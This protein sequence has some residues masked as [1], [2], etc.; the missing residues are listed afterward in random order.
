M[1]EFAVKMRL[2][3]LLALIV[4]ALGGSLHA[5]ERRTGQLIRVLDTFGATHESVPHPVG[6]RASRVSRVAIELRRL[7]VGP[8][9]RIASMGIPI[10]GVVLEAE[11]F[12]GEN[13]RFMGVTATQSHGGLWTWTATIDKHEAGQAVITIDRDL[14]YG[15]IHTLENHYT[16]LTDR[17]GEYWV[18][19]D[20]P[21]LALS[22]TMIVPPEVKSIVSKHPDG[23]QSPTGGGSTTIDVLVLYT[24]ASSFNYPTFA[25]AAN[26][27][28]DAD[29][30]FSGSGVTGNVNIVGYQLS[31]YTEASPM[32]EAAI[33]AV[34]VEMY[35]GTGDFTG[36]SSL[37][38]SL[39]AD[40]AVLLFDSSSSSET[41]AAATPL[42]TSTGD[43]SRAV[44]AIGDGCA[45]SWNNF[46]HELGHVLGGLHDFLP[47]PS[48]PFNV[49]TH[50]NA[51]DMAFGYTRTTSPS[52]RTVMGS[53]ASCTFSSCARIGLW[54]D[55]GAT[56]MGY[57]QGVSGQS[58]M[59]DVLDTNLCSSAGTISLVAG[60]ETP[61]GSAPGQPG[62]LDVV[63]MVCYGFNELN[64][65]AS[66][67]NVGWY[68]VESSASS[69]YTSPTVILRGSSEPPRL[70]RRLHPLRGWSHEQTDAVLT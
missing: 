25:V 10:P 63:S 7:F 16:I 23:V 57:A 69:M 5:E 35:D 19:E 11:V 61:S 28:A 14:V 26:A 30:T 4:L 45:N 12:P 56:Y 49:C 53:A 29:A 39:N 52:F 59:V 68:E 43:Y 9:D 24:E 27:A 44:A 47:S 20:D 51:G 32:N 58:Q 33:A 1:G 66:S 41:C 55:P 6:E 3:V 38:D 17:S 50:A 70:F 15:T 8:T 54:S 21:K 18:R 46:T 65:S 64:W 67:G 22:D 62:T 13:F 34:A 2:F 37:R 48:T 31:S 40:V 42:Y 60:Y 36:L